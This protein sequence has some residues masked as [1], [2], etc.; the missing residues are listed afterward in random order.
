MIII[1]ILLNRKADIIVVV[2]VR[3]DIRTGYIVFLNIQVKRV[4]K[5]R[6][7][8]I[9]AKK[10]TITSEFKQTAIIYIIINDMVKWE[11]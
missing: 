11:N 8:I 6:L 9:R 2:A 5:F 3:I 4:K 10:A 1:T 7:C